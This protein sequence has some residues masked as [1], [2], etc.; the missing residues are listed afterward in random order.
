MAENA[1]W[2]WLHERTANV[3]MNF[4]YLFLIH[5]IME[6]PRTKLH[7]KSRDKKK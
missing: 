2:S 3:N 1:S 7:S 4:S 6:V 5:C